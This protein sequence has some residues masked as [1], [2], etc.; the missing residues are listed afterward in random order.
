MTLAWA[1]RFALLATLAGT[2]SAPVAAQLF[3]QSPNFA[4][5]PVAGD[6]PTVVVPLSGATDQE[7]QANI[8]WTLRA[9][10]NVAALQ[11]QFAPS[12]MVVPNYNAFLTHH[13]TE[14]NAD[15]KILGGYFKRVAPK[16][17]SAAAI[18]V[19]L[20]RYTTRT[21]NS[22]ST[23][24][25]QIGYCQTASNIGAQALMTPKGQLATVART[26]LREFR[27]SLIPVGDMIYAQG[28]PQLAAA[29]VPDFPPDCYDRKGMLRK[30][31]LAD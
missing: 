5:G 30:K 23:L 8:V 17:T 25:A 6:E 22:F 20:D 3:W 15:Y 4:G 10:L 7:K 19:A 26:R 29:S 27:N 18:G 21:Y 16:G 13:A 12:L 1:R 31:C 14:L 11:C 24:N 2:A 28:R 9:G